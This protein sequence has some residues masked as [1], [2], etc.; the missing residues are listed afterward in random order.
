LSA[1]HLLIAELL[2]RLTEGFAITSSA[3]SVWHG[4]ISKLTVPNACSMVV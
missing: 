3:I 4:A 1:L 2:Y